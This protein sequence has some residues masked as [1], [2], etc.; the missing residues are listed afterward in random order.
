[1]PTAVEISSVPAATLIFEYLLVVRCQTLAVP[2]SLFFYPSVTPKLNWAPPLY[3]EV[4][5]LNFPKLLPT[6]MH[7]YI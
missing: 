4:S 2:L 6:I 7:L 1:M 3:A 5:A